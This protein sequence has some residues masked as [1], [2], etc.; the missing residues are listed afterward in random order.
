M[1][2]ISID[3][4]SI[5][6]FLSGLAPNFASLLVIRGL[7]GLGFGGEWAAGSV[8][9]AEVINAT[10]R[11]KAVG[12]VQSSWSIGWGVAALLATALF[13]VLPQPVAWRCLAD[14]P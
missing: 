3:W 7:Q 2:Q 12:M 8:L 10:H 9:M 6:T 14:P 4:F 13:Q 5:F 11:G 1:L